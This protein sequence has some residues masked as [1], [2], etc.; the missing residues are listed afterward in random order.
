MNQK[1]N[2]FNEY[3][4][5]GNIS[6]SPMSHKNHHQRPITQNTD[7]EYQKEEHGHEIR[8]WTFVVRFIF[9]G[10][11]RQSQ[12]SIRIYHIVRKIR[13]FQTDTDYEKLNDTL[14]TLP[15]FARLAISRNV[16]L[17]SRRS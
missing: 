15:P 13:H 1:C 11:V 14:N 12:I 2:V 17:A 16:C 3:L 7:H 4:R 10:R 5:I 9:I 6:H 8:F